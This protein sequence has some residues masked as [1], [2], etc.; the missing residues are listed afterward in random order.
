MLST[1]YRQPIDW[2]P[3]KLEQASTLL[4]QAKAFGFYKENVPPS[5]AFLEALSD[6][7]NTPKAIAVL[8]DLVKEAR[9]AGLTPI[10]HPDTPISLLDDNAFL[11][12]AQ[13]LANL[14]LLGIDAKSFGMPRFVK[15][16]NEKKIGTL[17]TARLAARKTKNWAEADRIRDELASMGI[18][19]KDSKDPKTGEIITTWEVARP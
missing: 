2:T 1:H 9:Y 15:A 5:Q 3:D 14:R 4:D 17:I 10:H 18:A 13:I 12:R 11:P 19:L 6:D 7:L 8:H 16:L